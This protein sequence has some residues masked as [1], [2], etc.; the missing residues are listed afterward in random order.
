MRTYVAIDPGGKCGWALWREDLKNPVY[1]TWVMEFGTDGQRFNTFM[2][3][4]YQ[5]H[6]D[7]GGIHHLRLEFNDNPHVFVSS[8]AAALGYGWLAT[9]RMFCARMKPNI[10]MTIVPTQSWRIGFIGKQ[11]NSLINNARKAAKARGEKLNTRD[12]VKAA[13]VA[14]CRQI[15]WD[16]KTDDEADA[17]GQLDSY[18]V[19]RQIQAPWHNE[20]LVAAL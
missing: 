16:P 6:K 4:L 1:G 19:D 18:L 14:R 2:K 9:A 12:M 15:G 17:L 5:L 13:T 10:S 8:R 3:K 7:W 11:E 20:A